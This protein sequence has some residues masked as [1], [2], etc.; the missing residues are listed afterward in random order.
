MKSKMSRWTSK[1]GIIGCSL[2]C[3]YLSGCTTHTTRVN[4]SPARPTTYADIQTPSNV[5]GIGVE[6]QDIVAMTDK[7]VRD[8][9]SNRLIAGRPTAPYVIIDDKYF[10]NE[11]SSVINKRLITERLMINLNRA[12]QGRMLFVERAASDMVEHERK[13]KRTGVTTDGTLG[14]TAATAG[15]D[16]R[17]AGKI[18]SQDGIAQSGMKSR[19]HMITFKMVDLETSIVA[20]SGMYEFKKESAEDVI[21]R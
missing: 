13:L 1:I 2:V 12:A 4:N 8:M 7:M 15:A 5:Q 14:R 21:Y 16:F 6:S 18:I 20:W 9:L 11:S 17:L 3:M 10:I 19:Y